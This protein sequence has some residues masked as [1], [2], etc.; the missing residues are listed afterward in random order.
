MD[1]ITP[2][3]QVGGKA[4]YS[5]DHE[6]SQGETKH[7]ADDAKHSAFGEHLRNQ[8][9][10]AGA[11]RCPHGKLLAASQATRQLEIRDIRARDE[12][13]QKQRTG[14][15]DKDRLYL[16]GHNFPIRNQV[17]MQI[18]GMLRILARNLPLNALDLRLGRL[19]G[20][21]FTKRAEHVEKTGAAIEFIVG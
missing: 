4:T 20:Y 14:Q 17:E 5:V 18:A 11:Q 7:S 9:A 15:R 1:L 10:A 8:R 2:G 13:H 3:Q 16:P 12:Q 21:A 6:L 19:H